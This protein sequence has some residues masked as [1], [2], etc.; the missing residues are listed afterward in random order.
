MFILVLL[1]DTVGKSKVHPGESLMA[2]RCSRAAIH[3]FL[4]ASLFTEN[5]SF[6]QGCYCGATYE[7]LCDI[8]HGELYSWMNW[9]SNLTS[10]VLAS[11][12]LL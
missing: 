6:V 1:T 12:A 7:H 9:L 10:L 5:S 2:F 4:A 11:A 3:V 8:F